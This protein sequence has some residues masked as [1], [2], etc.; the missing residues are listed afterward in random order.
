M[1][2]LVTFFSILTGLVVAI[3]DIPVIG[4]DLGL[5]QWEVSTLFV[6]AKRAECD[7]H[8]Q[9]V[10]V[11]GDD[12]TISGAV[13]PSKNGVEDAPSTTSIQLGIATIDVPN[14]FANV[15]RSWSGTSLSSIASY[16]LAPRI[17]F[18]VPD[19]LGEEPYKSQ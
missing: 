4:S 5:Q 16:D 8:S 9:P 3:H 2:T 13:G 14:R 18:E 7:Y 17:H 6:E 1:Y 11:V 15:V 19:S 12:R 10:K